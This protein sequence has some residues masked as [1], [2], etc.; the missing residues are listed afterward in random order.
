[1]EFHSG[2]IRQ[3]FN[4]EIKSFSQ[5]DPWEKSVFLNCKMPNKCKM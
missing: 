3:E 5:I 2:L 1:M 4:D